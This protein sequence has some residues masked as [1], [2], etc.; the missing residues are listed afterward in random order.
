MRPNLADIP[1]VAEAQEPVKEV[2]LAFDAASI[3]AAVAARV[4]AEAKEYGT[5]AEP[6]P[7]NKKKFKLVAAGDLCAHPMIPKWVV[8]DFLEQ[9]TLSCIYGPS[10]C[11]KSFLAVDWGLSVANERDWHGHS[12][13]AGPVIYVCGEGF[14]GIGK[15]LRSW[16]IKYGVDASRLPFYVSNNP[17]QFLDPASASE[18]VEAIKALAET[19][20]NPKLVIIDTLAR[21]FGPGDESGTEDM[22]RF[23]AALDDLRRYFGCAVMVVHHTGLAAADRARGSSAFRAALDWEYRLD[24]K[25]DVRLLSCTKA[26]DLEPP[27]DIAFEPES[28]ETGWFDEDGN[29]VTSIV[30]KQVAVPIADRQNKTLKGANKIALDAL[31]T[32]CTK[33]D[34]LKTAATAVDVDEWRE[35]AYRLAISP[36]TEQSAKQKAFRRALMSLRDGGYVSVDADMYWPT[37]LPRRNPEEKPV[38]KSAQEAE[39]LG[40]I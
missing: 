33:G 15:R 30:L 25:A 14:G 6:E 7:G 23:V 19:V 17:V 32:V 24:P 8:K 2:P 36:S 13:V 5:A 35:E 10:G 18:A 31:Y 16:C 29:P 26:K 34:I 22:S 9:D 4:A 40:L 28:V 27:Q 11:M 39:Q 20:G 21:N 38:I 12:V 37:D 1:D 3:R